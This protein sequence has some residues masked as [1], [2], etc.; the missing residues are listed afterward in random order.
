MLS[1]GNFHKLS[2]DET[3]GYVLYKVLATVKYT[4]E[5]ELFILFA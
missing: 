2:Q 3:K 1:L 5:L 4:Y